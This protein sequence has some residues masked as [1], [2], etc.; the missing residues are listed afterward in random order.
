[1]DG[2]II[3]GTRSGSLIRDDRYGTVWEIV[4]PK[5]GVARGYGFAFVQVDPDAESPL[6]FHNHTE[7]LY[8]ILEGSGT[9][10]LGKR[11]EQVGPGD[12]IVIPPRLHHKISGGSRGISF[13]C[14]TSPPYD[15]EDDLE[16]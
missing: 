13:I 9:M 11:D 12:T 14:V 6:H 5:S 7:E 8:H 10:T 3:R 16:L 2:T 4:P 15:P 1:M